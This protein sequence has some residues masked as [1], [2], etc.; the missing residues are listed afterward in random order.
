MEEQIEQFITYLQQVR[1]LS[2]NTVLSY[3]RDLRQFRQ[4]LENEQEITDFQDVTTG[5]LE[6]YFRV[7]EERKKAKPSTVS[8]HMSS[9]RALYRYLTKMYLV[10]EDIARQL[11]PPIQRQKLPEVLTVEEVKALVEQPSGNGP[12]QARDRAILELMY[13]TGIKV[14]ELVELKV[15]D[16]NLRLGFLHCGESGRE[17]VVPFGNSARAALLQYLDKGRD[18]LLKDVRSRILFVNYNGGSMSRQGVWKLVRKYGEQAGLQKEVNPHSLRHAFAAHLIENGADL[19][20]V[21]EMMGHT[22]IAAT[23]IYAAAYRNK[24]REEYNRIHPR[25]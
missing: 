25:G 20:S 13:A 8:R 17:R 10:R 3:R 16:L 1:K 15:S 23:Q 4:Y 24:V 19:Q 18:A 5:H 7:L 2:D 14:S 12:V 11:Q 9:V 22:D 21:Q 6:N